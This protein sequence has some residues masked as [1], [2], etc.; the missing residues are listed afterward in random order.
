M[1][2]RVDRGRKSTANALLERLKISGKTELAEGAFSTTD[3][4]TGQR[5]RLA[6]IHAWL[7]DRPVMLFD[8]WAADQDPEFRQ[9]FY[10]E[11][12]PEL[13]RLGKTLIVIS[14]DDR[15]FGVADRVIRLD[16]GQIADEVSHF[17]K[18]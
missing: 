16:Q 10:L 18:V 11:L 1:E 6:L 2:M 15:Y 9:V 3:L 8:E 13:K 12:L 4:S 17:G 5:K 14:H 7:E